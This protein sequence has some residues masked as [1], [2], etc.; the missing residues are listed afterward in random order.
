MKQEF[1]HKLRS[2]GE[3]GDIKYFALLLHTLHTK[4]LYINLTCNFPIF[5]FVA[6]KYD[7]FIRK[8][9]TDFLYSTEPK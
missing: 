1:L 4:K 3:E 2:E 7:N 8:M 5:N 6:S 9:N